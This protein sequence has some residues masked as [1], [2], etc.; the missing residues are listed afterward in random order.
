[1]IRI[2]EDND[3]QQY[4]RLVLDGSNDFLDGTVMLSASELKYV[5]LEE[6]QSIEDISRQFDIKVE[7]LLLYNDLNYDDVIKKGSIIYL[8]K[9]KSKGHVKYHEAKMGETMYS[10]SQDFGIKLNVLYTKNKMSVGSQPKP[11][12]QIWLKRTKK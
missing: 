12:Q 3:L 10:I 9:K 11:G 2:I 8:Q 4:D 5:V 7:R 6:N 1:L